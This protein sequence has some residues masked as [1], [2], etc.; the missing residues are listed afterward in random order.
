MGDAIISNI[1]CVVVYFSKA[2][3]CG[4]S[5]YAKATQGLQKWKL[6]LLKL[7]GKQQLYDAFNGLGFVVL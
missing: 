4:V 3:R 2:L 7:L 1:S 5:V 6:G